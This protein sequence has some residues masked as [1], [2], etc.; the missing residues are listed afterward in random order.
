MN[1]KNPL[2]DD[3][4][5]IVFDHHRDDTK[6]VFMLIVIA[7]CGLLL[8]GIVIGVVVNELIDSLP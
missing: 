2:D 8:A 7:G 3:A 5:A 4:E 1:S 6:A